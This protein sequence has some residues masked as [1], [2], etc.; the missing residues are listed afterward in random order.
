MAYITKLS[1]VRRSQGGDVFAPNG[2]SASA[3][4]EAIA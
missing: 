2:R 4:S 1:N 3:D